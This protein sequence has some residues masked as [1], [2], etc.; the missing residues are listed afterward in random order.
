MLVTV[1]GGCI[2]L[3]RDVDVD[4]FVVACGSLRGTLW[5]WVQPRLWPWIWLR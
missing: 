5:Q 4:F 3:A 1:V 2:D